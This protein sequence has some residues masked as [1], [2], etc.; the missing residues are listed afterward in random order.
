VAETTEENKNLIYDFGLNL[1]I[2]F[3][4]Q[5]DFLDAYGNPET[6]GKQVGGDII[7]NK[8][9][10]LYLKA[11]EFSSSNEKEQLLH[12]FS[13]QPTDNT[14]KINSVKEIFNTTGATKATQKAIEEYTLKAF[15]TLEKMNISDD[16]KVVLKTFGEKL[17][18]RNV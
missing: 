7:E 14:D 2:A 6:F 17:M 9:T 13:I 11:I 18:N 1:G 5:D 10:Y 8:K 16:K 3:Q 4:L 15:E 12:L